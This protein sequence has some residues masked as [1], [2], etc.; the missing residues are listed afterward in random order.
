MRVILFLVLTFACSVASA[1]PHPFQVTFTKM[2]LGEY[3]MEDHR[4][5]KLTLSEIDF[6]DVQFD[7]I[8]LNAV[9]RSETYTYTLDLTLT[10]QTETRGDDFVEY[11]LTDSDGFIVFLRYNLYYVPCVRE[12]SIFHPSGDYFIYI[13]R[14]ANVSST[15]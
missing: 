7:G 6:V 12:L 8:D 5:T 1:Q 14:L 3:S 13:K 4:T 2:Y 15:K 9:Y 10:L 11:K